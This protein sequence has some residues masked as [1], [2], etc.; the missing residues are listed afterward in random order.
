MTKLPA[1]PQQEAIVM[2]AS[3]LHQDVKMALERRLR[4]VQ[5]DEFMVTKKT[6]LTHAWSL[7]KNNI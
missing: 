6:L 3:D 7:P 5:V 4:I 1:R 2:Q